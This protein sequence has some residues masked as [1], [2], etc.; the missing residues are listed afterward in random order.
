[1]LKT[2]KITNNLQQQ[3]LAANMTLDELS[4]ATPSRLKPA[5]ISNW[6]HERSEIGLEP[7]AELA[8]VLGCSTAYLLGIEEEK[9]MILGKHS[10]ELYALLMQISLL[11]DSEV[12]CVSAMLKAYLDVTGNKQET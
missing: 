4:R 12:K 2:K 9:G 3:R 5:R 6:E 11:G 10:Q 7:A 1:M 8:G